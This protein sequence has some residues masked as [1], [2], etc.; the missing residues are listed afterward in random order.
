MSSSRGAARAA[1]ALGSIGVPAIP[2]AVLASHGLSGVSLLR[3]LYIA[4]P[5]AFVLGLVAVAIARRAR[6]T[7]ARSVFAERS[8]PVRAARLL[9]WLGVYAGVTGALALGV[10]WI[11]RARH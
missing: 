9:A 11:L 5:V 7:A 8:G 2:A 10:Y 4:V 3:A 6:F 1:V